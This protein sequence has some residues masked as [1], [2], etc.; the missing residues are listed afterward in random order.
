MI[1]TGG[2]I[3]QERK[4]DSQPASPSWERLSAPNCSWGAAPFWHPQQERIY[5]VDR[6]HDRIWRLHLASGRTEMWQLE[7]TPGSLAP[8]RSGALLLALRDG[9]YLSQTWHDIPQRMVDAP[10]TRGNSASMTAAAT[11]G[12][13]SGSAP[14]SMPARPGA[15]ASTACTSETD[16]ARNCCACWRTD[17]NRPAWPGHMTAAASTGATAQVAASITTP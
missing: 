11:P 1:A 8:C 10:M 17:R 15:P 6:G 4:P 12:A 13:A 7:Q 9:I 2:E 3:M 14:G 5:W 16:P